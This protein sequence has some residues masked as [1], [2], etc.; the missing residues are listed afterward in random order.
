MIDVT[1]LPETFRERLNS[2]YKIKEK[3][4]LRE[5]KIFFSDLNVT[6]IEEKLGSCLKV[7]TEVHPFDNKRQINYYYQKFKLY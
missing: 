2:L 4:T 6:N 7:I 3:W 5:L 1:E